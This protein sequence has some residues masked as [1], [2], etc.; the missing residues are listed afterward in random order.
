MV[1]P[2]YRLKSIAQTIMT[3]YPPKKRQALSQ[4]RQQLRVTGLTINAV[5][6]STAIDTMLTANRVTTRNQTRNGINSTDTQGEQKYRQTHQRADNRQDYAYL[7][8]Q[9]DHKSIQESKT[10][11][12]HDYQ[13]KPSAHLVPDE[14]TSKRTATP[15]RD[16]REHQHDKP[17]Y[18]K[19]QPTEDFCISCM[20]YGHPDTECTKTG[21]H[22]SIADY[23]SR[24]SRERKQE[25]LRAYRQN[26][27]D[28]HERYKAAYQRRRDLRKRIRHLEYHHHYD[29]NGQFKDI[30]PVTAASLDRQ[31]IS[32]IRIAHDQH[33]DLDFGSLDNDYVDMEE[34][35]LNFDPAVDNVPH[36]DE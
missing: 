27:K 1:P 10:D 30:D 23:L 6:D 32:C 18:L 8:D 2:E 20:T 22:I 9:Y 35:I 17:R 11:V 31:R 28:A 36:V 25:I 12:P 34:P 7:P 15:K 26:R 14:G 16:N 19:Q 33:P 21:A 29:K 3:M 24:C 4:T 5:D 13:F